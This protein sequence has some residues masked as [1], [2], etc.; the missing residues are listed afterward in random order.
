MDTVVKLIISIGIAY[1]C[2]IIQEL[3]RV[4]KYNPYWWKIKGWW[5]QRY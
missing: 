5:N 2:M 3:I 1:L 4:G